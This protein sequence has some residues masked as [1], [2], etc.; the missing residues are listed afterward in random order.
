MAPWVVGR[1]RPHLAARAL[2]IVGIAA[3]SAWLWLLAALSVAGLAEQESIER[4]IGWCPRLY[5]ADGHVPLWLGL[6]AFVLL[7]AS[8]RGLAR[9][10]GAQVRLRRALP[11]CDDTGVLVVD[12]MT[13]RAFA[14]PGQGGGVVVSRGMIAALDADEQRVLW[15]HERAHLRNHH[16][17][18]LAAADLMVGVLPVLGPVARRLE[19][20]IER[21]ADEDSAER[22]GDRRVVARAIAKAALASIDQPDV[23]MAMA[24]CGVPARVEAMLAGPRSTGLAATVSPVVVA[25][26]ATASVAGSTIQFHHLL[27]F[28]RHICG[29]A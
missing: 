17:R 12:S 22:T 1:L 29:G 23:R 7:V 26:L 27:A 5:L 28:S 15:A 9:A 8:L 10:F 13:P 24:G 25:G 14:V 4:W 18:F 11:R 16:H 20:A 6:G 3:A 19:F 2:L 21:W